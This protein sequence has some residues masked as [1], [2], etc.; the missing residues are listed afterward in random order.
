MGRVFDM[1]V[2]KNSELAPGRPSRNF[3]GRV[4]FEGS[5]VRDENHQ[6]A[7]FQHLGANPA[8]MDALRLVD[9]FSLLPGH[10]MEQADAKQAYTQAKL[11]GIPTW[12]SLP[13]DAWPSSW[14][15]YHNPVCPLRLALYGH[16][17]VGGCWEAHCHAS[18][19]KCG[20][21]P[22][23]DWPSVYW[24]DASRVL[25]LVYVDD[26]KMA[27]LL[28]LSRTHGHVSARSS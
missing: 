25:L 27:G 6:A 8:S 7:L 5:F 3:K 26:F 13:K 1:C 19:L 28:P 17:D 18:L 11:E 22:V 9:A 15:E 2:E 4:V 20:F 24:L 12:V 16:P 14:S 21:L 10:V 23:Q